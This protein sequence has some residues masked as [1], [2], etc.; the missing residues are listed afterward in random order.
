[1]STTVVF[2]GGPEP[3]PDTL[4][5]IRRRLDELPF[6][7]SVAADSGLHLAQDLDVRVDLVV[8]DLD[9]V[10]AAR[11]DA[12]V[13]DG[14]HVDRHP[15]EKD[16]TDLEL[17]LDQV[18][19]WGADRAVLVGSSAGRMDQLLASV[20]SI[21]AP[22]FAPLQPEAW[23]GDDTV[24]PI[25]GRRSLPGVPGALVSLIPLH[26]PAVGVRTTG[27]QWTL[28]G[29]TLEPGT[30]RGVSNLFTDPVAHVSI[31]RGSLVA[32]IPAVPQ[33]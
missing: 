17:A 13:A 19:A 20:T 29:D 16:A 18:M 26:G 5:R 9:S 8:G 28:D 31:E 15:Q 3:D 33:W 11:L 24:I 2:A 22:C 32:V 23:L 27:L 4:T 10:D 6:E 12:A 25:H 14:T 1:M 21:T 7:R 30:S